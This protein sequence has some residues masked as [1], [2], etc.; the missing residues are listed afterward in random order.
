MEVYAGRW[1]SS[2]VLVGRMRSVLGGRVAVLLCCISVAWPSKRVSGVT[3]AS[4][5][6]PELPGGEGELSLEE[7]WRD[8]GPARPCPAQVLVK[9]RATPS[10][11]RPRGS[12]RGRAGHGATRMNDPDYVSSDSFPLSA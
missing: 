2:Q 11:T 8:A 5:P 12:Y 4:A 9:H 7:G 3:L 1:C 10:D 6:F